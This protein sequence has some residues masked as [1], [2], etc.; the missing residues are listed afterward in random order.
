VVAGDHKLT[1]LRR[2]SRQD[3]A[4]PTMMRSKSGA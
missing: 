4:A 1:A 3:G 2:K